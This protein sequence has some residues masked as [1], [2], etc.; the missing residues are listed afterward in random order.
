MGQDRQQTLGRLSSGRRDELRNRLIGEIPRWYRPW[1]HLAIPSLIGLGVV[2]LSASLLSAV[3]PLELVTVPLTFLLLNAGEWRIH[4]DMLHRRT[5]PLAVLYDR[6][7]PQHHMIFV[8]D[9]MAIRATREFYLVLIPAYGIL[10]AGIGALPIPMALWLG[11][12]LRNPALMFMAMTM[13]YVVGY[14]WLHL[15]YHAPSSSF[16]GRRKIIQRLRRHHAIHHAPELMQKW[17]FNVTI[18]LWD[19]LRGTIYRGTI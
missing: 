3:R 12:G 15:S 9:D 4:R 7:T 13:A 16:V 6:H 8:T 10:A 11:F 18:P 1:L 2:A 5:P 19:W 14:E 17:N